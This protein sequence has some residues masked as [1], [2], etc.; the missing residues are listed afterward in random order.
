VEV[1]TAPAPAPSPESGISAVR[2]VTLE[3][4]V[5]ELSRGR[6]PVPPPLARL[7]GTSGAVEVSFSVGAGGNTALQTASGPDVLRYAAE[8]TVTSWVFRRTRAERAYLTAV[9][10]YEGD[11]ASAV[12]RP[13]S[14]QPAPAA[15]ADPS[16]A[17]PAPSAPTP[18][19]SSPAPPAAPAGTPMVSAPAGP[20]ASAPAAP[21]PTSPPPRP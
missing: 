18:E 1:I 10:R 3:S 19:G 20:T 14:A 6:R 5:P 11:K 7:N 2:D 9:F 21:K 8:Q 12:V 15:G 4:G 13:Q 16:A 17:A